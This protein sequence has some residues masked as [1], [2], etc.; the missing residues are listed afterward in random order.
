V[1]YSYGR[2]HYDDAERRERFWGDFD[3]RHALTLFGRAQVSPRTSVG[4]AFRAGSNFPI[5][6]YL[7][8]RDGGLFIG[9]ERNGLRLPAYARL[10]LRADRQFDYFHRRLTAFVE[11]LNVLN[12]SNA[13]LTGGSIDA[14]TGEAIGLSDTLLGRRVSAGVLVEF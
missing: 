14:M 12:R 11:M 3:Q 5:P 1:A 6:G 9:T 7:V 10:D 2:T 8:A 4:A 13:G